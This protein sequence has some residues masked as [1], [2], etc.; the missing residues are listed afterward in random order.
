MPPCDSA[1]VSLQPCPLPLKQRQE[2]RRGHEPA[3]GYF[4]NL[5]CC[6]VDIRLRRGDTLCQDDRVEAVGE[7]TA[8]GEQH[9]HV[10]LD[11]SNI[12]R[13]Y[14]FEAEESAQL[15]FEKRVKGMLFDDLGRRLGRELLDRL[16]KV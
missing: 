3:L 1:V 8:R 16:D 4:D 13:R 10:R 6:L 15:R 9:A 2:V 7:G 12:E 5:Q 11:A 14:L